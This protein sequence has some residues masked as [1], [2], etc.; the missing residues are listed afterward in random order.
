MANNK[1][2]KYPD[3]ICHE[4]GVA[5]GGWYKKGVYVGPG[6]HYA[7]MH[8]GDCELCGATN[9]AVTEPRDYGYLRASW[10]A[11]FNAKHD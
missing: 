1:E 3:W 2:K 7:T 10:K 5:Y 11:E 6:N 9:V 8:Q 4:C